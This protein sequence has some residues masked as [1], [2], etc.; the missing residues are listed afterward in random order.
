[1]NKVSDLF[2]VLRVFSISHVH[3]NFR[4][5]RLNVCSIRTARRGVPEFSDI[6]VCTMLVKSQTGTVK[7]SERRNGKR[8]RAYTASSIVNH[9]RP[10]LFK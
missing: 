4:R 1:M 10:I 3:R 7:S 8:S 9:Y 5:S 6:N 2:R